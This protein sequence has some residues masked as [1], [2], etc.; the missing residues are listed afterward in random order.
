[1]QGQSAG[2][3]QNEHLPSAR[4]EYASPAHDGNGEEAAQEQQRLHLAQH[5]V[6]AEQTSSGALQQQQHSADALSA[7]QPALPESVNLVLQQLLQQSR[8]P[9]PW[10]LEE[11]CMLSAAASL[12]VSNVVHCALKAAYILDRS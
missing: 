12:A 11:V 7:Q 6:A 9:R 5:Q 2:S 8:A 10:Q 3:G 1:M 4:H